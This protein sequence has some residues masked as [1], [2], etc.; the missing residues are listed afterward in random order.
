MFQFLF[1]FCVVITISIGVRLSFICS[2]D[3]QVEFGTQMIG[4]EKFVAKLLHCL[5]EL[6]QLD[7]SP[8]INEYL[9]QPMLVD[10]LV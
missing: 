2:F 8:R 4:F 7:F 5:G 9:Q 3:K 10:R 1:S 6:L